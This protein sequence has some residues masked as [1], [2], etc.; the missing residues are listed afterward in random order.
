[1]AIDIHSEIIART[2]KDILV[3]QYRRWKA[4][5][6]F[7]NKYNNN[8]KGVLEQKDELKRLFSM[9][10]DQGS[11]YVCEVLGQTVRKL[12]STED[13]DYSEFKEAAHEQCPLYS[14][15]LKS[16]S[17]AHKRYAEI[18]SALRKGDDEKL[19][20]LFYDIP[21]GSL[22]KLLIAAKEHWGVNDDEL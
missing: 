7:V 11:G 8:P 12:K 13:P 9:A 19:V 4:F 16:G 18:F 22:E 21:T 5:V 14:C 3:Q 6:D 20:D 2:P 15:C 1:M 10:C 17:Q